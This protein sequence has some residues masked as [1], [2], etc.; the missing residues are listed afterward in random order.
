[1]EKKAR[2]FK[3][4]QKEKTLQDLNRFA[5]EVTELYAKSV[6][7][8]TQSK[9]AK[10][11]NLTPKGLRDLM[12]YAIVTALVTR[13]TENLVLAKAMENQ[14][15]KRQEAGASSL[16]HYYRLIKER[17]EYL[18]QFFSK[19]EVKKIAEHIAKVPS[20]SI[21]YFTQK[22]KIESDRITRLLL[23]RAIVE[24]IVSDEVMEEVIKRSLRNNKTEFTIQ[25][26]ENLRKQREKNKTHP[27]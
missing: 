13:E 7:E 22:Y 9:V 11:N 19:V 25:Y 21:S 1:M 16:E 12:D 2:T 4:L 15:R 23:R 27:C 3:Q 17:E 10:D 5:K 20:M 26:F 18:A 6:I 14:R 24:D 8:Y